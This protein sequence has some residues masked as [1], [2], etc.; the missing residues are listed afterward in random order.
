MDRDSEVVRKLLATET[1]G[2]QRIA[3]AREDSAEL[4]RSAKERAANEVASFQ[5]VEEAKLVDLE[6]KNAKEIE[7]VK[8]DLDARVASEVQNLK[9]YA[10]SHLDEAAAL[11]TKVVIGL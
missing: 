10:A 7:R 11:V 3:K 8:A 4:L 5:K 1:D 2:K 6:A 9:S